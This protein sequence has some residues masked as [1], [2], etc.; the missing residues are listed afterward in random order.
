MVG[1]VPFYSRDQAGVAERDAIA[2]PAGFLDHLEGL[3]FFPDA[4]Q[5][6]QDVVQVLVVQGAPV[7]GQERVRDGAGGETGIG[8]QHDAVRRGRVI[9]RVLLLPVGERA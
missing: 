4:L 7:G 1:E 6:T 9:V 2:V 3:V 5:G 8:G